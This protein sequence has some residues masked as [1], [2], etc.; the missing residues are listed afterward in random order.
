MSTTYDY[1]ETTSD[2]H[3]GAGFPAAGSDKFY[4]LSRTFDAAQALTD[5]GAS[6]WVANDVVKLINIPARTLVVGVS[7]YMATAGAESTSS[8]TLD[9]GDGDDPNGWEDGID[10]TAAFD[11]FSLTYANGGSVTDKDNG[12]Y[13]DADTIDVV[14]AD[15]IW[16][17]GVFTINVACVDMS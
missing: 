8:A 11:I 6:A 10:A 16:T 2:Q 13:A 12:F 14:L 4:V 17:D 7:C 3:Y 5:V 15:Q 9:I 1:I